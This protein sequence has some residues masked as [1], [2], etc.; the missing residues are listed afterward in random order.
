[1]IISKGRGYVFVHIPKTGGTALTL[2]LEHRAQK[3]D[4]LVGDTPK[5]KRRRH[6]LKSLTPTGR[7]WKHS[8]LQ[9]IDGIVSPEELSEMFVFTL[10]RN[11]WDR[12]VS[13][14]HWLTEQNFDHPAVEKAAKME[15]EPFVR[16]PHTA[17]SFRYWTYAAYMTDVSGRER[18]DVYIRLEKLKSDLKRVWTH[19]GFELPI[20]HVNQSQRPQGYREFYTDDLRDF[21]GEVCA[22]D[23]AQFNYE[24]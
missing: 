7:L 22:K 4:I 12:M 24:F 1:M 18:C 20:P 13:Y 6:R 2:A 21:V 14:Y 16:D 15:F 10:V 3:D 11:P 17:Q 5:A 23:I 9:D 8:T 19:L